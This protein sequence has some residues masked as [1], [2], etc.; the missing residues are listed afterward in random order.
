MNTSPYKA[1]LGVL[2]IS[3]FSTNSY[4]QIWQETSNSVSASAKKENSL[5]TTATTYHKNFDIDYSLLKN[6]LHKAPPRRKTSPKDGIIIDFPDAQGHL[7]PYRLQQVITMHPDLAAKYPGI[8][9]YT[10]YNPSDPTNTI[11]ITETPSGIHATITSSTTTSYISP[12]TKSGKSYKVYDENAIIQ[13]TIEHK[14]LVGEGQVVDP[15]FF[16]KKESGKASQ[17]MSDGKL[18]TLRIALVTTGEFSEYYIDKGNASNGTEQEK[19]AAVIAGLNTLLNSLN[20]LYE[21]EF[22]LSMELVAEND[23]IIFL[24]GATDGLSNNNN[25]AMMGEGN[26]IMNR[27]I[28]LDNFDIGHTF[29]RRNGGGGVAEF[30]TPCSSNRRGR[31]VTGVIQP[32]GN[33]FIKLWAHEIGHQFTAGHTFNNYCGGNRDNKA[34]VEPGSGSSIMSYAGTCGPNVLQDREGYYHGFTH[35]QISTFINERINPGQN[36]GVTLVESNNNAPVITS[37]PNYTIPADTPFVLEAKAE[38]EDKDVL[39][40]QF[41]QMDKDIA[42]APP[43]ATEANGPVF[44]SY[45]P[46]VKPFRFFP[47]IKEVYA[48]NL[49][50]KWEMIPSITR[51]MTFTVTV[52]DVRNNFGAQSAFSDFKVNFV[53]TEPFKVTSQNESGIEWT[54]GE[55]HEITW[56]VAGTT[57]NGIDTPNVTIRLVTNNGESFD[58]VLVA[59]TPNDGSHTITIPSDIVIENARIMVKG[60][61]NVFFALNNQPIAINVKCTDYPN[62]RPL[63]IPDTDQEVTSTIDIDKD[64]GDVVNVKVSMDLEHNS[65]RDLLIKLVHPSGKEIKLWSNHCENQNVGTNGFIFDDT[66]KPVPTDR[67]PRTLDASY[68]PEESLAT[69]QGLKSEGTWSLVIKDVNNNRRTGRLNNW[70]LDICTGDATKITT[71]NPNPD[72]N[73]PNPNPDPNNPDPNNPD[74]NNNN[75][76]QTG[77][78]DQTNNPPEEI[79]V[80]PNPNNGIFTADFGT[81]TSEIFKVTLFDLLGRRVFNTSYTTAKN[82]VNIQ[83]ISSGNYLLLLE[84]DKNESVI[85]IIIE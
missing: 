77:N 14:C 11:R 42:T 63:D 52:R 2:F 35:K 48:G 27:E 55:T 8:I 26:A 43:E 80:Y 68:A 3:I 75:P 12:V 18:R 78:P 39:T 67:C 34:S 84:T 6:S 59:S 29:F 72:P 40:Y 1:F 36:C 41:D 85:K 37:I 31:A 56:D 7:T 54:S 58:T 62:Q 20:E 53:K 13:E 57:A 33:S 76:D 5:P 47:T 28:G 60:V 83:N 64:L 32:E 81:I 38:D 17:A 9:N 74:P 16:G 45:P 49:T 69:F 23:K 61:D 71:P 4:S 51:E 46:S 70:S 15:K 30:Y 24:D 73:N 65:V 19:K 50:P 10:G 22:S 66:A 21:R 82:I 25:T 44:R 79:I